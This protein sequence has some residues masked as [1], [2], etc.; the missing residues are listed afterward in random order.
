MKGLVASFV[1]VLLAAFIGAFLMT[2]RH[3]ATSTAGDVPAAPGPSSGSP[4]SGPTSTPSAST[5]LTS[6][7]GATPTPTSGATSPSSTTAVRRIA[8]TARFY[9][10]RAYE[11]VH[12]PG[13]YQGID[14]ATRLRVQLRRPHGWSQFPLPVITQPSG[15]F[16]AY[17][18]LGRGQYRLRL[19]DP[20]TGTT[21]RVLT[22]LVL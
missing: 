1:A 7:T 6:T 21:S 4:T 8:T 10:G 15:D 5:A 9:F 13:T 19:V 2:D 3:G 14:A 16:Q 12:I 11:T 18:E 22:L 20:A 17:V